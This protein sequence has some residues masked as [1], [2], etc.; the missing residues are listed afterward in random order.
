M[1]FSFQ[2]RFPGKYIRW[3]A[4]CGN[5]LAFIRGLRLLWW[6]LLRMHGKH[7]TRRYL[8]FSM[9]ARL[10]GGLMTLSCERLS[11]RDD[12]LLARVAGC[13]K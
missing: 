3:R 1:T 4:K 2:F 8:G 9:L 7:A 5:S 6:L 12:V 11:L 10:P 13:L